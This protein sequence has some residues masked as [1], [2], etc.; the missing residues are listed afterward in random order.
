MFKDGLHKGL[1][2]VS[3][4]GHPVERMQVTV[5][6]QGSE[7]AVI[8]THDGRY[9]MKSYESA[10]LPMQDSSKKARILLDFAKSIEQQVRQMLE[11]LN[12]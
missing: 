1:L 5:D 11:Q 12:G 8:E 3:E 10:S 7:L 2:T 6:V 4:V 9:T